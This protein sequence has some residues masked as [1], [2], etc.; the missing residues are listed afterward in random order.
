MSAESRKITEYENEIAA[1][2]EQRQN[3]S[4]NGPANQKRSRISILRIFV[5][6][7]IESI[8]EDY[9]SFTKAGRERREKERRM[10]E[11]YLDFLEQFGKT[12]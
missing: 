1:R 4:K 11:E 5:D 6:S 9:L 7:F 2:L 3:G 8:R 10:E 12:N